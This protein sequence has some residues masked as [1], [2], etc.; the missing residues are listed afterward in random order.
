MLRVN[1]N[2]PWNK[3]LF[4]PVYKGR[5][6]RLREVEEIKKDIDVVK[7]LSDEINDARCEL[8]YTQVMPELINKMIRGNPEIY[9]KAVPLGVR[10]SRLSSL[11]NVANWLIHGEKNVFLQDAD[12][13]F[14][15]SHKL[16]EVVRYLKETLPTIERITSFARSRTCVMKSVDEL[17]ELHDAGFSRVLVGLESG[18]DEV[19]EFMRKGV[20]A[21]QHSIGGKNVVESG[22]HLAEFIMPGL[23]GKKLSEK[24]V[25][26]TANVLNDIDPD[27]IKIR[28]LAVLACS[29]LHK[30]LRSGEF[31][32][33]TEDEMVDEIRS[34]IE[35]LD[36]NSCLVSDQLTNV[37]F[38]VQG[39]LPQEKDKML[40][41]IDGY[42][43]M[44]L[45]ERLGFR[46]GRYIDFYLPYIEM[47]NLFDQ[48]LNG[49]VIGAKN[50]L[51][52]KSSDAEIKVDNAI[53][54][55]KERFIP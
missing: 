31:K 36:C 11:N 17:R 35:N 1:R 32:Q 38:E 9:G 8:G 23:G 21:D 52:N 15:K 51:E 40:E 33:L 24:H 29:L 10:I 25:M 54:A 28:S 46:L 41:I 6:F 30:K 14:T 55:M 4:C 47:F 2:C 5:K 34:L 49:L 7:A 44:P 19:L 3:C 53:L 20:T 13:L 48:K 45:I 22:I 43:E 26:E 18:C 12:A 27:L 50:A 37:L 39:K 42:K 16:V